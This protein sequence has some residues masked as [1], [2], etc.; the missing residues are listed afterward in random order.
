M[1]AA[2]ACL[3]PEHSRM[4]EETPSQERVSVPQAP[5]SPLSMVHPLMVSPFLSP[6][7]VWHTMNAKADTM[8]ITQRVKPFMEWLRASTVDPQQGISALTSVDPTNTTLEQSQGIR[9]SLAPPP[10]T[11][12]NSWVDIQENFL[13]A[14][15]SG[16]TAR[17]IEAAGDAH[18]EMG[19]G[20]SE[21]P[22]DV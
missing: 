3:A 2:L 8:G 16:P 4:A 13:D 22:L 11:S 17:T 5:L 1:E 21:P 15:N 7:N 9:K 18:R 19:S 10:S 6:S 20:P 12:T 14:C